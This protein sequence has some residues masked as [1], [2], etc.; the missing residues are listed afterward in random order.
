M[1]LYVKKLLM[2]SILLMF[3]SGCVS[4]VPKPSNQGESK[5]KEDKALA[6]TKLARGYLQKK[7]YSVAKD[8]LE[9][10]LT[11]DPTHSDS[12]Y[13]MGLLMMQLEQY[14]SAEVHFTRAVKSNLSL[15]HI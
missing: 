6:Y 14:D 2:S 1:I 7:Q 3:L 13:V 12:N 11:I 8:E 15:I 10:A 5:S 9:K 4:T